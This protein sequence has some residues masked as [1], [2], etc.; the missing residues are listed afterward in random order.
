MRVV[1]KGHQRAGPTLSLIHLFLTALKR[2]S[3]E[4]VSWVGSDE[5]VARYGQDKEEI[6]QASS[7]SRRTPFHTS[8]PCWGEKAA[9]FFPASPHDPYT[10]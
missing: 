9:M 4:R 1:R 8:L 2:A 6:F 10:I 5:E 7:K 3:D